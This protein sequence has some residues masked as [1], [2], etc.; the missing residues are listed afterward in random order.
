MESLLNSKLSGNGAQPTWNPGLSMPSSM[1]KQSFGVAGGV[2][3]NPSFSTFSMPSSTPKQPF[4]VTG[5]V[6]RYH[7]ST[8]SIPSSTPKQSFGAT[9]TDGVDRDMLDRLYYFRRI[10]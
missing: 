8:F 6:D 1:P 3:R 7:F 5:G 9:A 2:D 10:Y 4:G